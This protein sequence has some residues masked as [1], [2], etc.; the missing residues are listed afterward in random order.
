MKG[1]GQADVARWMGVF[2]PL[3]MIR[4][5][6]VRLLG[7]RRPRR[8]EVPPMSNDWLMEYEREAGQRQD[9]W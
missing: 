5:L 7:R 3:G 9:G 4:A 6:V 8:I 1:G 2:D